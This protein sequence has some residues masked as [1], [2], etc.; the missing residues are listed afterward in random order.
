MISS[1][2]SLL[3][4]GTSPGR[5]WE[6]LPLWEMKLIIYSSKNV[7]TKVENAGAISPE[8]WKKWANEHTHSTIGISSMIELIF[9][10]LYVRKLEPCDPRPQHGSGTVPKPNQ[11]RL[12]CMKGV[13]GGRWW[14]PDN[15]PTIQLNCRNKNSN[16]L[17]GSIHNALKRWRLFVRV[18]I[19]N[20]F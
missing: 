18:Q 2:I 20:R 16:R 14:Q 11:S 13:E 6:Y 7:D 1:N 17:R 5:Y 15:Q 12:L 3:N 19:L 8:I 10:K 4:G 9:F